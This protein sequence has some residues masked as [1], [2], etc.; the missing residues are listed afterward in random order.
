M[1]TMRLR[2]FLQDFSH[3]VT[4]AGNDEAA[5]LVGGAPLLRTLIA[6]DDW[7]LDAFARPSPDGYCQYLLYCDPEKRFSVVSFIWGPGQR[8]PIH[9]HTVWGM[10]GVLCGAETSERFSRDP[11]TGL[12]LLEDTETLHPGDINWIS[13]I[14]GD[15]HRVA[16]ALPDQVSISIHLYGADIGH[17]Q[18]HRFDPVTGKETVFVSGYSNAQ[19]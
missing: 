7:L 13:P 5:L 12:L 15:I 14:L 16:N 1:N 10:V 11:A 17:I 2:R 9:D 6:H 4:S 3:L 19:V 8:T 18:R